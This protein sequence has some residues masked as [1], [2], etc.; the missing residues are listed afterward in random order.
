MY[1]H[2]S[3]P[4]C[5][6][7][8]Q[9]IALRLIMVVLMPFYTFQNQIE[10]G[11]TKSWP[12]ARRYSQPSLSTS[13]HTI[14]ASRIQSLVRTEESGE[15]QSPTLCEG[16]Q[17]VVPETPMCDVS[18]NNESFWPTLDCF[19]GAVALQYISGCAGQPPFSYGPLAGADLGGLRS[20][21]KA[22]QPDDIP[23]SGVAAATYDHDHEATV[24]SNE[25]ALNLVDQDTAPAS[26][27]SN[28]SQITGDKPE[29]GLVRDGP[30]R[31]R[32]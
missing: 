13:D 19:V 5:L 22:D 1:L 17:G 23:T 11:L 9:D 28:F 6:G 15:A 31:I 29:S 16:T 8:C 26:S 7:L 30:L 10:R 21:I 24:S 27:T 3:G 12:N 4:E 14:A 2:W 18:V 25:R 20:E 32:I